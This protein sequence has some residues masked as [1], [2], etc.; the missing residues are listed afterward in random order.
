MRYQAILFDLDNTLYDLQAHWQRQLQQVL[1]RLVEIEPRFDCEALVVRGLTEK[2]WIAELSPFL[3]RIGL[4]NEALIAQLQAQ[5]ADDWYATLRLPDETREVLDT[6]GAMY[7]LGLITNGPS[8]TQRPKIVQFELARWMSP[9]IV[10]EEV[11]WAKP[12]PAIFAIALDYLGL[13]AEQ[14]VY[15][16]D[17]PEFDLCGAA[18]AKIEAI[19][20]NPHYLRLPEG[21]PAPVATIDSLRALLEILVKDE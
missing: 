13:R 9:L 17:S 18:A 8:R 16:G 19:W 7:R 6:L 20:Y 12:D 5:Y 2:V 21:V 14:V 1:Q 4:T 10:S 15:V 11:G 3:R